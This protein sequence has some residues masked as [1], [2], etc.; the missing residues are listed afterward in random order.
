MDSRVRGNDVF[1]DSCVLNPRQAVHDV[2]LDQAVDSFETEL[3]K[4]SRPRMDSRVRGNDGVLDCCVLNPR[5]AVHVVGLDQAVDS[6]ED[7][8]REAVE[9]SNG[10]P[11]S[12]E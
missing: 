2:G 1:L 11:R 6:F 3:A 8:T 7:G 10:F 5:Q 12:R 4:P 9:A